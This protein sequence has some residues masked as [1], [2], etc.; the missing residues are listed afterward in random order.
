MTF[1]FI[2]SGDEITTRVDADAGE[3]RDF[4]LI[5]PAGSNVMVDSSEGGYINALWNP[6]DA[7]FMDMEVLLATSEF[8][9]DHGQCEDIY[10]NQDYGDL[11]SRDTIFW[12]D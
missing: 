6:D 7:P 3:W 4:D 9:H 10:S 1:H 5:C 11:P 2:A 12:E 8:E